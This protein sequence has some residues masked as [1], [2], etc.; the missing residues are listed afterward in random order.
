MLTQIAKYLEQQGK[1]RVILD[2]EDK[3]VYLERYYLLF[4]NASGDYKRPSWFPVNMMLHHL[5][6]SDPEGLHDHPWWNISLVLK[7]GYWEHLPTGKVW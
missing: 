2:R 1:K 7:G 4:G 3:G 6:A 5:C